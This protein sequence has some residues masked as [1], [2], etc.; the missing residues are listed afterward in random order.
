MTAPDLLTNLYLDNQRQLRHLAARYLSGA[1]QTPEDITQEAYL[2]VWHAW[3]RI[4]PQAAL[5]YLRRTVVNLAIETTRRQARAE[6]RE[7]A[8]CATA[9]APSAEDVALARL[10]DADV[11]AALRALP[12]RQREA[13]LLRHIHDLPL[14][15]TA[16]EMGCAEGTVKAYISRGLDTLRAHLDADKQ[17]P[18]APAH[19]LTK[20]RRATP[21]KPRR[22]VSATPR[23]A[24]AAKARRAAQAPEPVGAALRGA[25]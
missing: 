1:A 17:V 14:L 22:A 4:D 2:R 8:L 19:P 7:G 15:D 25:A 16:G 20:P 10:L 5:A 13:I 12:A 21:P 23:R 18:A 11:H 24:A 9:H 6:R 3:D